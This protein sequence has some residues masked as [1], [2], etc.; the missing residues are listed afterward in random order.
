MFVA[1]DLLWTTKLNWNWKLAYNDSYSYSCFAKVWNF[2][3][4]APFS[5]NKPFVVMNSSLYGLVHCNSSPWSFIH[6][7]QKLKAGQGLLIFWL[8]I[9]FPLLFSSRSLSTALH[10]T[11]TSFY[12]RLV[13]GSKNHCNCC[14]TCFSSIQCVRDAFSNI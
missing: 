11:A 1:A 6:D 3:S 10:E 4:A 2:V 14:T 8:I 7:D 5:S 12:R 13:N 9:N